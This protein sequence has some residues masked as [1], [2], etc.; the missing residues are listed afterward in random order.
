MKLGEAL[1]RRSDN[2]KRMAELQTRIIR[3]AAVQEGEKPPED[4]AQLLAE[5]DRLHHETLLLIQRIN[6]TNA[7][8]RFSEGATLSDAIAERE[9][10]K[11][12]RQR[13]M[14]A[15]DAT[16]EQQG[17]YLKSEIRVIRTMDPTALRKRSDE[18]ARDARELDIRIQ[19]MNWE[20]DLQD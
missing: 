9:A 4:P 10:L 7:A 15:A 2:Q 12:L 20:V 13:I 16:T 5:L 8:T 11:E 17:R 1:Q 6:R 14:A 3:S 18:L 19:A